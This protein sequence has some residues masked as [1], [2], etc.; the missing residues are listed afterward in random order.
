VCC[1]EQLAKEGRSIAVVSDAGTPG[2]SDPGKQLA[3]Q[4]AKEGVVTHPIPGPSAAIA[5][6]S[7]CGLDTSAFLFLGFLPVSGP[8]RREKIEEVIA[9][10]NLVVLYEAPHRSVGI[11]PTSAFHAHDLLFITTASLQ[12]DLKRRSRTSWTPEHTIAVWSAGGS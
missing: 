1:S 7:V 8:E 2:I 5:A 3:A 12:T 10:K 9:S 11:A 4:C 6:L